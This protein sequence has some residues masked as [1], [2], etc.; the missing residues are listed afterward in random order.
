MGVEGGWRI[1]IIAAGEAKVWIGESCGDG[2]SLVSR[3]DKGLIRWEWTEIRVVWL[4]TYVKL[5]QFLYNN[6]LNAIVESATAMLFILI[7]CIPRQ[8]GLYI[9]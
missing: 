4:V 8:Q 2:G 9:L 7:V 3:D 6:Y 5:L 1:D